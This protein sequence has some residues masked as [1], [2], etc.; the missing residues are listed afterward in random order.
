MLYQ[1][2]G[3]AEEWSRECR[4]CAF[5]GTQNRD[6]Y[7]TIVCQNRTLEKGSVHHGFLL[8]YSD[9]QLGVLRSGHAFSCHLQ[10]RAPA[11]V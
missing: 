6:A 10:L 5:P 2:Q 9:L 3:D 1:E 7:F 4:P 11:Q 8:I